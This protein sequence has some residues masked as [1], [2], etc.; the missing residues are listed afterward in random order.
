L[1]ALAFTAS[2]G[3]IQY[4][5]PIFLILA[6]LYS[7][8]T[9]TFKSIGS[10]KRPAPMKSSISTSRVCTG[11]AAG[12]LAGTGDAGAEAAAAALIARLAAN[13]INFT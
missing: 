8:G 5:Y 1:L 9:G 12:A 10:G 3:R 4:E 2:A 11:A 13:K 7:T 6:G